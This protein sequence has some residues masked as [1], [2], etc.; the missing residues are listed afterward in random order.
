M[1][2]VPA[3]CG[4]LFIPSNGNDEKHLFFILNDACT[5]GCHLL[6]NVTTIYAGGHHD[7][8]CILD[9]GDH[10]FLKHKSF[11]SYKM[12]RVHQSAQLI[13][14][15]S[16]WYYTPGEPA[17]PELV[18]KIIQGALASDYVPKHVWKYLA[19]LGY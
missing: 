14:M 10:P 12:A 19:S 4:T 13:K 6:V 15:V 9:V 7:P 8:A 3:K 11:I 5:E 2:Y 17:A 1:V 18:E 16:S